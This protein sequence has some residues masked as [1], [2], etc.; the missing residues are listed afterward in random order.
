MQEEQFRNK[1]TWFTF[2]FSLLV[3]WV[4]SYNGE[5]FLGKTSQAVRLT[6]VER[7]FGDCIGQ[8]AVPGFFLISSYLFYRNFHWNCLKTKWISRAKSILIPYFLWNGIYYLGYVIG[9]RL[10]FFHQAIGKGVIPFDFVHA[11]DA[12]IFHRY[13][14]VFWYLEQLILLIMLAP[15]LYVVLK[16]RWSGIIFLSIVFYA[17]WKA[18]DFPYLNEDALF[19]YG[20][21]AF[22]ALQGRQF[23][24]E[25]KIQHG[26]LGFILIGIGLLNLYFTRKYFLPGTTVLY[27]I[28]VPL[29]LLTA[30]N[31]KWL[32]PA[33]PWMEDNFFL[34]A[35]HF[36]FVR[37]LNKTAAMLLPSLLAVPLILYLT[38]PV[39]MAFI[40]YRAASALK[41]YFPEFWNVLN[42]GR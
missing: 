3:I 16:N 9:S 29:G 32:K 38:M 14:Y 40:S 28:L 10:P 25:W 7:V 21:G 27:R 36:S 20:T 24:K 23:E 39:L 13:L 8:I 4:H 31:E 18:A 34:Y 12:V 5:L 30:V 15:I 22:L 42:G 37:L 26:V 17:V 19:Y 1:I 33:K 35:I 6:A 2:F 11:L 41:V